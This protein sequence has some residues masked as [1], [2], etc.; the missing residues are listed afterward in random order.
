M[1]V[2]QDSRSSERPYTIEYYYKTTWGHAEEFLR[3]YR[4]NHYPVLVKQM[5][6]SRIVSITLVKPRLHTTEESRWDYR[7]TIVWKNIQVTDDGFSEETLSRQLFPDY[8]T[9][10]KEEQRRFEIL[11]AHWD[12]PIVEGELGI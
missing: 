1:S 10:K 11:Q 5:E 3:L 6:M 12:V 7:V 9:F 2:T 4:K 8:E